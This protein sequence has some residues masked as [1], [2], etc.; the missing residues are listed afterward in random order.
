VS[1][2]GQ[3]GRTTMVSIIL[4]GTTVDTSDVLQIQY[5]RTPIDTPEKEEELEGRRTL[6]A[7][8]TG[9][10]DFSTVLSINRSLPSL[11]GTEFIFGRNES[12]NQN[13]HRW[14]ERLTHP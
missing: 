5:S 13:L 6:Y 12:G 4:P 1:I 8:I 2:S 10:E 14:V 9:D 3:P 11:G 7:A